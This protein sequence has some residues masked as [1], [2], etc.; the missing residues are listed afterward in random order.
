MQTFFNKL[1]HYY[2][3]SERNNPVLALLACTFLGMLCISV[4]AAFIEVCM[5][6]TC[7]VGCC[8][9]WS[10]PLISLM[11]VNELIME[12]F[13]TQLAELLVDEHAAPS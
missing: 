6:K 1:W 9:F 4:S 2:S 5:W 8:S 7:T 12:E 10:G 13:L 3:S 11:Q